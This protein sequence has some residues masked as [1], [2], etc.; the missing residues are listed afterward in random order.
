M[1]NTT[2]LRILREVAE[3]GTIIAAA[4]ALY[5]TPPAVSHQLKVLEQELG[6]PLLER[7]ARSIRLTDAGLRLVRHT[8][9]ILADCE[10]AVADVTAL[11]GEVTGHLRL[12]TF[13]TAAQSFAL[14][15]VAKIAE[16]YPHLKIT[17]ADLEPERA[18][19]AVKS[20][21][22]DV[23][24]SHEWDFVP[25]VKD[26]GI[27][28]YPLLDE[29]IV[30]VLPSKHP[31]AGS[32]VKVADLAHE[33]WCVAQPSTASRKAVTHIARSAGFTLKIT[34]ES[35]YFRAIGSAIEAGLGVGIAPLMTD[36]RGLDIVIQPLIE[37][38]LERHIFAAVRS[39]SGGSPTIKAALETL[40]TVAGTLGPEG[41]LKFRP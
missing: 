21:Q 40:K 8:E 38:T 41:P 36:L 39:G 2:R 24:L 35:N 1:L 19:A 20:G 6:V 23:A 3:R 10:T 30:V 29:P 32:P 16:K 11:A 4:E 22:I 31:L 28:R 17:V 7:T 9:T 15:A 14:P 27:D 12:S 26:P 33:H 5:L 18:V 25:R 34:F 37:P 13:Q